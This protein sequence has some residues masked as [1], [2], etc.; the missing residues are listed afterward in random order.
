MSSKPTSAKPAGLPNWKPS[1]FSCS[2]SHTGGYSNKTM[3]VV[4]MSVEN[5]GGKSTSWIKVGK[6]QTW[7]SLAATGMSVGLK[8]CKIFNE[9]S[10]DDDAKPPSPDKADGHT[11]TDKEHDPMDDVECEYVD[12]AADTPTKVSGRSYKRKRPT[13]DSVVSIEV[14]VVPKCSAPDNKARKI[15]KVLTYKQATFIEEVNIPWLLAYL[16]D[17]VSAGGVVCPDAG[18]SASS[19]SANA[20]PNSDVPGLR[21]IWDFEAKGWRARFV[22]GPLAVGDSPDDFIVSPSKLTQESWNALAS[23]NLVA[24]SLATADPDALEQAALA[25]LKA[26]CK[27]MVSK[28]CQQSDADAPSP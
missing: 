20:E 11:A 19:N 28:Q 9:L 26:H 1:S 25:Y 23:K 6:C 2:L 27:A 24:G 5:A 17:E 8:R 21:I 15:V 14:D 10:G 3:P 13:K 18:G 4:S 22:D 7:L 12:N 16:A